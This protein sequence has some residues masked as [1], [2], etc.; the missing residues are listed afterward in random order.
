MNGE[1]LVYLSADDCD[2]DQVISPLH[3]GSWL[4]QLPPLGT[5]SSRKSADRRPHDALD[6]VV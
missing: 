5:T 3:R 4:S 2:G 6:S 1:R